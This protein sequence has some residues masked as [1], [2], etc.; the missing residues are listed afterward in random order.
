MNPAVLDDGADHERKGFRALVLVELFFRL[1]HDKPA[2]LIENISEWRVNF[3]SITTAQEVPEHVATNLT[4]VVKTR[5]TFLLLR[6]E[7]LCRD[8]EDRDSVITG[9]EELCEGIESLIYGW[10]MIDSMAAYKDVAGFWWKLYDVTLT[11]YSAVMVMG[12]KIA[13]LRSVLAEPSEAIDDV[14]TTPFSLEIA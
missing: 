2:I 11:A 10:S 14:S 8:T 3:P 7:M 5:L 4:L 12:R 6:F 13:V 1:L 9:A